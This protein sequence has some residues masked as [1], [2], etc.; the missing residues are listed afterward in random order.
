MSGTV[1]ADFPHST[2]S[3]A[4]FYSLLI[5]AAVLWFIYWRLSR[6]HLYNL[7]EKLP[8]PPGFPLIGNALDLTGTS[9]S[10]CNH[11]AGNRRRE[12]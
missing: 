8:G 9:H 7:A 1:S 3:T 6:R 4:V 5:P 2:A 11:E 12:R 10:K